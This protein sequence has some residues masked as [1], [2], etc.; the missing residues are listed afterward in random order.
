MFGWKIF[1]IFVGKLLNKWY[2]MKRTAIFFA[3]SLLFCLSSLA[4][5]TVNVRAVVSDAETKELLPCVTVYVSNYKGAVSNIDGYFQLEVREEDTLRISHIGYETF[6]IV[7]KEAP[8]YIKLKPLSTQLDEVEVMSD[9]SI[10]KLIEKKLLLDYKKHKNEKDTYMN[11]ISFRH[12]GKK[13]LTENLFVANSVV[14]IRNISILGGNFWTERE[15]YPNHK[16]MDSYTSTNIHKL[17]TIGPMVKEQTFWDHYVMPFTKLAKGSAYKYLYDLSHELVEIEKGKM[18]Y[19]VTFRRMA[20]WKYEQLI[21]YSKLKEPIRYLMEGTLYVDPKDFAILGADV[22]FPDVLLRF[23]VGREKIS[24]RVRL[25]MH[26][27]YKRQDGY[28][29]IDNIVAC[30]HNEKVRLYSV[31]TSVG[32][33]II[34]KEKVKSVSAKDNLYEAIKKAGTSKKFLHLMDI[35]KRTEDEDQLFKK[36]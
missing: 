15:E 18:I 19:K 35:I 30:L 8:K 7:A 16:A 26:A 9:L 14:N 20:D 24:E 13:E 31:A 5:K 22:F 12:N 32:D 4:Q 36:P 34:E 27:E 17:I 1:Y 21:Q 28:M 10:M 6:N 29:E 3:L 23:N 33:K 11:R 25:D 2:I